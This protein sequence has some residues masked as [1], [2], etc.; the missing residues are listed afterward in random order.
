MQKVINSLKHLVP[1]RTRAAVQV[2]WYLLRTRPGRLWAV[3][4]RVPVLYV[5]SALAC[6]ED[7]GGSG[8][9]WFKMRVRGL[10]VPVFLRRG[11]SDFEVF[12]Q[13][14]IDEQY[15]IDLPDPVEFIVDAGA[16]IGRATVY[17]VNRFRSARVI[18]IEPD[19]ENVAVARRNTAP[20]G[21]RCQVINAAL[22]SHDCS[23]SID[24]AANGEYWA[25]RVCDRDESTAGVIA[26]KCVTILMSE[27]AIARI[28]LFKCDI[29]GA[30]LQVFRHGDTSFLESTRCIAIECHGNECADAVNLATRGFEMSSQGEVTVGVHEV[31]ANHGAQ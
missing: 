2:A 4:A 13:V 26:A 25:T 24:R 6:M 21:D 29:E 8:N 17:F 19:P 1:A 11:T 28:D 23:V 30:E 15:R 10:D 7:R 9:G 12:R 22:W 3:L 16:N 14:F 20:Y 5:H 31:P 18:A 27:F